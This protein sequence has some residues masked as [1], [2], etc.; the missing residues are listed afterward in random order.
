MNQEAIKQ[1]TNPLSTPPL[2]LGVNSIR[3]TPLSDG[4]SA[5]RSH[6]AWMFLLSAIK[7]SMQWWGNMNPKES[8][9]K[10]DGMI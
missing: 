8:G 6:C 9:D 7:S 2:H 4:A 3:Q 5:I 1:Y 10:F